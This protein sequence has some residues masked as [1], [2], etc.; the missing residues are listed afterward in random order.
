MECP[1]GLAT[2]PLDTVFGQHQEFAESELFRGLEVTC[3][4]VSGNLRSQKPVDNALR[5]SPLQAGEFRL[6]RTA[7]QNETA[8]N[9]V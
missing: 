9:F 3:A 6:A 4:L 2:F 5:P 1:P 7:S 8:P